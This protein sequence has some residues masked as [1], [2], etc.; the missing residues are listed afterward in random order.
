M[1]VRRATPFAATV[2]LAAALS[3]CMYRVEHRLPVDATFGR[4]RAEEVVRTPFESTRVKRY[5]L[6]GTIPWTLDFAASRKLVEAAPGRRIEGLE[7]RTRFSPLDALLRLVPYLSYL[8][9]QRT[10]EV[11]GVY[12]DSPSLA[13]APTHSDA[14]EAAER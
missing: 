7:I 1:R 14:R 8:L 10:V 4:A 11:R 3:G 13:G 9:A 6:G 2:A 5:L 12:V